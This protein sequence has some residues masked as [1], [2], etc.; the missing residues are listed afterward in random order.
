MLTLYG[1]PNCNTVKKALDYLNA[2]G[3]EY[4]FHNYKK[5]GISRDKLE[6]WMQQVSLDKLVNKKGT[7]YKALDQ[8]EKYALETPISAL[9][10]LMAKPSIIKRPIVEDQKIIALGFDEALYEKIFKQL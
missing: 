7:T 1:I 9:D 10:V 4:T 2:K 5:S 6:E 8:A 3:E